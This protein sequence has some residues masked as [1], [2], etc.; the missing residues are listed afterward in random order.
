MS[1]RRDL[2]GLWRLLSEAEGAGA[3][4]AL[5][6]PDPALLADG[7]PISD[8]Q[9]EPVLEWLQEPGG[10]RS[11]PPPGVDGL[12]RGF[13]AV[14]GGEGMREL[15]Q[16]LELRRL[17]AGA[18]LCAPG[19]E[20]EL[21]G[22]TVAG[23]LGRVPAACAHGG[24]R[25][26]AVA[27]A[28]GGVGALLGRER[29]REARARL[30]LL[31]RVDAFRQLPNERL[32]ALALG[33]RGRRFGA[34]EAL[35]EEGAPASSLFVIREGACNVVRAVGGLPS[36]GAAALLSPRLALLSRG[37][38]TASVL[39]AGGPVAALEVAGALFARAADE[40]TLA[41]MWQ[42]AMAYAVARLPAP[43]LAAL[44]HLRRLTARAA[45][46]S[47]PPATSP[48]P[49]P[50]PGPALPGA[51]P[52]GLRAERRGV[53]GAVPRGRPSSASP[54][55]GSGCRGREGSPRPA[56]RRAVTLPAL[57]A[58]RGLVAREAS[59]RS[60]Q[61]ALSIPHLPEDE[62]ERNEAHLEALA[63]LARRVQARA[64][65]RRSLESP[66]RGG[67]YAAIS[68]KVDSHLDSR[69]LRLKLRTGEFEAREAAQLREAR[70]AHA[71][72]SPRAPSRPRPRPR[73]DGGGAGRAAGGAG[74]RG[75]P[76]QRG[77][78][79]R[80]RAEAL[81]GAVV[82]RVAEYG[83]RYPQFVSLMLR[84]EDEAR[85]Q[86]NP[87][88]GSDMG[89][90]EKVNLELEM[91]VLRRTLGAATRNHAPA[92]SVFL[93]KYGEESAP[94]PASPRP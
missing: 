49:P 76:D 51:L 22:V 75:G 13:E 29:L 77:P 50:G 92:H 69:T 23:E 55:P 18:A 43:D 91:A 35:V 32:L 26:A 44:P 80:G 24:A 15:W 83:A 46:T 19:G 67:R 90:L 62:V 21:A 5:D 28:G 7:V 93:G 94:A 86:P 79:G 63:A 37:R 34:G 73:P 66:P 20:E 70:R 41:A 8:R 60:L 74:R 11:A 88:A 9:I 36:R 6:V 81:F 30:Q 45:P 38:R 52:A 72:A 68:C 65:R 82:E 78:G 1:R 33:A 56:G 42:A 39:A 3:L 16:L 89:A 64:A 87:R 61:H 40:A 84:L 58:G 10:S 12:L 47:A 27:T 25:G 57:R 71:S 48:T 17:E 4:E 85:R 2:R 53:A 14:L 31:A 54:S 59:E